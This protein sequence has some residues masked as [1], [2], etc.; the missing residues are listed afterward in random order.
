ML[1]VIKSTLALERNE[2][3][4]KMQEKQTYSPD[5]GPYTLQEAPQQPITHQAYQSKPGYV[6]NN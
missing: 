2:V 4:S 6:E 5:T 1:S 3:K